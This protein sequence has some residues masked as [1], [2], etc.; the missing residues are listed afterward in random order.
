MSE[1]RVRLEQ[2][3]VQLEELT[4]QLRDG[5]A[6]TELATRLADRALE[7]SAEISEFLPRVIREI[8]DEAQGRTGG[9]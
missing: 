2:A 4:A 1:Q 8:E 9:S 5:V 6:D 3:V 7:L